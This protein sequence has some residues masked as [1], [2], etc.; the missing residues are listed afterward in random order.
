M[1]TSLRP[2]P[3]TSHPRVIT[4]GEQALLREDIQAALL[5]APEAGDQK[6]RDRKKDLRKGFN[7]AADTLSQFLVHSYN[8]GQPISK[9]LT[10]AIGDF[11][12]TRT[13]RIQR[14]LR[15]LNPIEVKE[16]GDVKR[17]Q[18]DIAQ[19]DDSTPTLIR[20]I[21]ELDEYIEVLQ[22]MR[23]AAVE[24]IQKSGRIQ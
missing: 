22:E 17:V 18:M 21:T 20:F 1:S 23:A 3:P 24:R 11:F 9:R 12:S 10:N 7:K 13:Q 2:S 8:N 14:R 6:I 15:E 5:E 16:C 19:G 4:A